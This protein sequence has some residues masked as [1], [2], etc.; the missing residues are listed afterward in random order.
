MTAAHH[1]A[2]CVNNS[3]VLH[4]SLRKTGIDIVGDVP[5]GTHFCMFYNS[6]DDLLDILIPYFRAGLENGEFCMW[7]TSWPLTKT[8]A[9]NAIRKA[10]A[11]FDDYVRKGQIEILAHDEWYVHDGIFD[12]DRVLRGWVEKLD[13]ASGLGFGGLRLTGNTFWLEKE[14]WQDFMVY[15]DAVNSVIGNYRML[16]LCTY[17]MDRCGAAEV[18]DVAQSHQFVLAN[19]HNKWTMI[20]NA[21][22]QKTKEA[23]N[24]RTAELEMLNAELEALTYTISHDLKTPLRAIDGFAGMILKDIGDGLDRETL[25]KLNVIRT[26]AEKMSQLLDELLNLSRTGRAGVTLS[27][28]DMRLLVRDVWQELRAGNPGRDLELKLHELPPAMADNALMRQVLSN[29]LGNAVKFTRNREHAEIEVSSSICDGFN[30]YC[31][32]DNGAGFDMRYYERL[33]EVFRR[34]HSEKE[35][36]GTGVGLAIVKKI[37]QKHG[38][39]IWAEGKPGEGSAFYFTIPS[40]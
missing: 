33:F 4:E 13:K 35:F 8:A 30:A 25:R 17:S 12:S 31:I 6:K 24:M 3:L 10:I 18:L 5:W 11:G 40:D 14:N 16:A 39:T 1:Q 7:I 27:R 19:R 9:A 28:V 15:E 26:N 22:I 2:H 29:L 32:R 34:L 37:I 36:E 20:E 38:G 21:E 23:L